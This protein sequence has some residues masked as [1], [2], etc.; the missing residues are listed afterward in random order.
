M[1]FSIDMFG[2]AQSF[3]LSVFSALCLSGLSARM[4]ALPHWQLSA[5]EQKELLLR[6]LSL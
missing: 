6:W 5:G 1:E 3:N 2:F 4:R